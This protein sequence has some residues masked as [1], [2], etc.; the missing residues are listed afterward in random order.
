MDI[1]IGILIALLITLVIGL[2]LG[3][4]IVIAL[5]EMDTHMYAGRRT[6]R[7]PPRR[8]R[9]AQEEALYAKWAREEKPV[10][11]TSRQI[12]YD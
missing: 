12:H 10:K 2:A 7:P 1:F 6:V 8:Y 5:R 4:V 11:R 3:L 9:S